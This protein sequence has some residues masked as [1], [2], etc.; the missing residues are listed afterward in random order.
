MPPI[1]SD[2]AGNFFRA[3]PLSAFEDH[4][5]DEMR[6]PVEWCKL[7][8]RARA[9]PDSDGNRMDVGHAFRDDDET[10]GQLACGLDLPEFPFFM[11]IH[12]MCEKGRRIA[13]KHGKRDSNVDLENIQRGFY[14]ASRRA[15][16]GRTRSYSGA[17]RPRSVLSRANKLRSFRTGKNKCEC[18]WRAPKLLKIQHLVHRLFG[19]TTPGFSG[20]ISYSRCELA[21]KSCWQRLSPR[22]GNCARGA[23][24]LGR[25]SSSFGR[26]DCGCGRLTHV[27][28]NGH[29]FE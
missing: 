24:R 1:R 17:A 11:A 12:D 2:F 14:I 29:D 4:V 19:R 8:A 25:S 27:P 13:R 21:G 16:A 6:H 18:W 3:P 22:R 26:G 9:N 28:A 7:G 15:R 23:C 5:F 20:C 10:V